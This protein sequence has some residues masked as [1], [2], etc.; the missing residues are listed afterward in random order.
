MGGGGLNLEGRNM[1]LAGCLSVF[2][3]LKIHRASVPAAP[4][5]DQGLGLEICESPGIKD[6]CY[7]IYLYLSSRDS[8]LGPWACAVLKCCL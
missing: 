8:N 7:H 4:G 6:V 3:L 2:S 1:P 5:T